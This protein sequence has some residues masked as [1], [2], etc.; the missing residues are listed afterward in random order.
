MTAA[1]Q[2]TANLTQSPADDQS[3]TWS[4]D[5]S[6]IAFSR[7]DQANPNW[8]IWTMDSDGTLLENLTN[9]ESSEFAPHW[10]R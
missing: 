2:V 4:P 3:P 6:Q 5:G 7:F 9:S 10:S 8:E 1:G